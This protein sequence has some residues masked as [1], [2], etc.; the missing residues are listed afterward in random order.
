ME[1]QQL[2]PNRDGDGNASHHSSDP[3][4]PNKHNPMAISTLT[5]SISPPGIIR[6]S[7]EGGGGKQRSPFARSRK[8]PQNVIE[9]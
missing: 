4:D 8:I 2:K 5:S 9:F 3:H 1:L 7:Q 6:K